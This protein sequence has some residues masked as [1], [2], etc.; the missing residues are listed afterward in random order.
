M[1]I[2][3]IDNRIGSSNAAPSAEEIVSERRDD[4]EGAPR[5]HDVE[6]QARGGGEVET[7]REHE[8]A[9]PGMNG[10]GEGRRRRTLGRG[11][12]FGT[13]RGGREDGDV[14]LCESER[15]P[16]EGVGLGLGLGES[17]GLRGRETAE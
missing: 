1:G 9:C 7:R 17:L 15:R 14:M 16:E 13:L 11:V 2:F 4:V 5:G 10:G 8:D 12:V 3:E 6:R